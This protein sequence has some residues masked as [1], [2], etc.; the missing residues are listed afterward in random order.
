M[1]LTMSQQIEVAKEAWE[2][3]VAARDKV[4]RKMDRVEK[5]EYPM[6]PDYVRQ[7]NEIELCRVQYAALNELQEKLWIDLCTLKQLA[8]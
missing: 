3:A 8:A 5:K 4:G 1:Y 6:G 2:A 7:V